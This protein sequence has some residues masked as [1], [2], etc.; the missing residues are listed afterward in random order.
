VIKKDVDPA[1][2][3]ICPM[4]EEDVD[5]ISVIDSIYVRE[6]RPE[7]YREELGSATMKAQ[8]NTPL[9]SEERTTILQAV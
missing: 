9:V 4:R 5:A 1:N 7:Y 2:N 8:I 3:Q 6:R